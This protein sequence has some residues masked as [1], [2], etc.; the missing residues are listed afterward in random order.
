MSDKTIGETYTTKSPESL[1]LGDNECKVN[2]ASS[3][4]SRVHPPTLSYDTCNSILRIMD[5]ALPNLDAEDTLH[6]MMGHSV[7]SSMKHDFLIQELDL[8]KHL[9]KE[10]YLNQA[11]IIAFL[12]IRPELKGTTLANNLVS[13]TNEKSS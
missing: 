8:I 4:G 11:Q 10:G 13:E 5:K 3:E 9:Y 6:Y 1:K 7:I 12:E 2:L